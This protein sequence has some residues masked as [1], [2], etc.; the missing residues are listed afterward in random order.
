MKLAVFVTTRF[1][2]TWSCRVHARGLISCSFTIS[3]HRRGRPSTTISNRADEK[4]LHPTWSI[5]RRKYFTL[6]IG[7]FSSLCVHIPW[8][9]LKQWETRSR[10]RFFAFCCYTRIN[11]VD[12]K[13]KSVHIEAYADRGVS[14]WAITRFPNFV[15]GLKDARTI[16]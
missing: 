3:V 4:N 16:V 14:F 13:W 5:Y 15:T 11:N 8:S 9:I 6:S 7:T 1:E 10:A 12:W 2:L